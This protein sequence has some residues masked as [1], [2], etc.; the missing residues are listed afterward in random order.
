MGTRYPPAI[1]VQV[2]QELY[3]LRKDVDPSEARQTVVDY[4]SWELIDNDL[5]L[6][7]D[8]IEVSQRWQSSLWDSLII[9]A[10]KRS[11]A[12]VIWSEDFNAGQAYD[13]VIVE[14]PLLQ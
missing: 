6:L 9:A 8:A 3:V 12:Q 1:S 10:A 5:A 11:H 7:T 2:L 4:S 13:G 14:N